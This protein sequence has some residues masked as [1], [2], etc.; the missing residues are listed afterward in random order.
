MRVGCRGRDSTSSRHWRGRLGPELA[1]E[2]RQL[3]APRHEQR[4]L[5]ARLVLSSR[6]AS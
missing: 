4:D 5:V 1:L 6:A 3:V 2:L